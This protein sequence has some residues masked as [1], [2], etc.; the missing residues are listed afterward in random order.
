M[1]CL[2]PVKSRTRR[3]NRRQVL[4]KAS[5]RMKWWLVSVL[6]GKDLG[7]KQA[8]LGHGCGAG[9]FLGASPELFRTLLHLLWALRLTSR[10]SMHWLLCFLAS[11][12]FWPKGKACRRW[13]KSRRE[14]L[15]IPGFLP[16]IPLRA[17]AL[18]HNFKGSDLSY[19]FSY[20]Q[21]W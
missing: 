18:S 9:Y 13:A 6:W 5:I 1:L 8:D 14:R 19:S 4:I 7:R 15:G 3:K 12:W 21:F 10:S 20:R 11:W 2:I 17:C 16:T